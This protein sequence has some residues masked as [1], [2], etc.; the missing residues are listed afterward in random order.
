MITN[1][2]TAA[3]PTNP[4]P[5]QPEIYLARHGEAA[6]SLTGQHTGLSDIPLTGR[7]ERK[8]PGS[9]A[10]RLPLN[11]FAH[12]FTSPLI[13]ARRTCELAGFLDRA[14]SSNPISSNGTTANTK[15][16]RAG[17]RSAA[18]APIGTCFAMAAPA[19]ETVAEVAAR[20]IE[21]S[22]VA[23]PERAT[24]LVFS[25]GHF[26]PR[27]GLPLVRTGCRRRPPLV[28]DDRSAQH[29]GLRTRAD[30]AGDSIV[31]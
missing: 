11:H 15:V 14:R 12:V 9:W 25:S 27:A 17:P 20:A 31:E 3:R 22:R 1:R 2:A 4:M 29:C 24:T 10:Q 26:P 13:R 6:W 23:R 30:V 5:P 21:S 7:G 16:V 19:A 8:A 18:N 28:F